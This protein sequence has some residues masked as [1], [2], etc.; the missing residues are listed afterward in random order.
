MFY[1]THAQLQ[2]PLSAQGYSCHLQT[3]TI[4]AMLLCF[5]IAVNLSARANCQSPT[6]WNTAIFLLF[7]ASLT[8][9]HNSVYHKD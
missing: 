8:C 5:S 7:F 4:Q 9:P 1:T 3:L 2:P 6:R